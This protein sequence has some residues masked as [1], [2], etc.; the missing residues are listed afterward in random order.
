MAAGFNIRQFNHLIPEIY[1]QTRLKNYK[2][3]PLSDPLKIFDFDFTKSFPETQ[4]IKLTLIPTKE[5]IAHAIAFWFELKL[6]PK[7]SLSTSPFKKNTHWQQ[8]I[9]SITPPLTLTPK[10]PNLLVANC[11][12]RS[13]FFKLE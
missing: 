7:I 6:N 3:H 9:Y 10:K 5:G 4:E 11:D 13:I 2:W 12:Q 8:A 1:L